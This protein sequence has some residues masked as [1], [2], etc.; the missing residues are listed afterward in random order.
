MVGIDITGQYCF[1]ISNILYIEL[2]VQAVE[3][4]AIHRPEETKK[5]CVHPEMNRNVGI[6]RIF[7]GITHATVS[8]HNI[9]SHINHFCVC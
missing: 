2:C 9:A 6:L 8:T 5:F 3:Y 4:D 7:P 1:F